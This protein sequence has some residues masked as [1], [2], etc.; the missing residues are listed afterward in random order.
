MPRTGGEGTPVAGNQPYTAPKLAPGEYPRYNYEGPRPTSFKE[1]PMSA[2]LVRQGEILPIEQRLPVAE[3]VK[4]MIPYD[5]IGVYGGTVR[6]TATSLQFVD[7]TG[8]QY[9]LGM[10]GQGLNLVPELFTSFTHSQD[11]RVFTFTIP[12]GARWSDGYPFTMEDVRF[13][14]EDMMLNKELMP[15]LPE[16]LR[17][18]I[19]G[20]DMKFTVVDDHTFTVAFDDPNWS[21]AE[22][23]A[24]NIFTGVKG[25]PRCFFAPSHV[26]KRYHIKYNAAEMPALLTK[27]N[28]PDWIKLVTTIRNVRGFTGIP[29]TAVPTTYDPAYIYKGEHYIPWMGGWITKEFSDNHIIQERNHYFFGVDP[30]GN[31]LP[32]TDFFNTYR[33]ESREVAVFRMMAGESDWLRQDMVLNEMPLYIS[34][35]EK[36]D[37]SIY[38]HDSPDGADSTLTVNQEFTADA[39]LGAL[40]RTAL[41]L[42]WDRN[43]T[44]ETVASGLGIPQNMIPHQSTP[45][46]PGEEFRTLDTQYD[47]ARAKQIMAD[48]G[49][50]DAN[51][52]GFLD[53]K[54]GRG[55][56]TLFSQQT[57]T[58]FPYIQMQQNDWAKLG[59]KLDIREDAPSTGQRALNPSEYFEMW[60]STEGGTNPW[61]SSNQRVAP[62]AAHQGAPAIGTYYATRGETG[63]SPTG[64][65]PKYTDALGKQAAAGTYPA[66]ITGSLKKLQDLMTEGWTVS[67]LSPE[68]IAL[69]KEMFKINA[70]EK[71]QIGGLAFS[72][73]FRA[74]QEKRNNFRN[75]PKNWSPA[76]AYPREQFYFEDGLDNIS[77]N[78]NRSEKYTSIS[79]LS[80]NYWD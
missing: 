35:M 48:L 29:S 77:H 44:N 14:M 28:Q 68:R 11:G 3:D 50:T 23:S 46:F 27:Y 45:Y 17:S 9:G 24:I 15:G 13:A 76:S 8:L 32:Y 55:P 40:L 41:S 10:D 18:P 62:I 63:M 78:G 69:G 26:Y 51:G 38:K 65:D 64:A 59:I 21:F 34:N 52:D 19:T 67:M 66:D 73:I 60:S 33:V 75:V 5:E 36:G 16:Q 58:Y 22:S 6:V 30:E 80:P 79:F 4:V 53:R 47:L 72:G 54:D 2:D 20:K 25:C 70:Q 43:S 74:L 71:Y 49:Y 42:A 61:S 31:Q 12:R 56:L 37:Y 39:E 57:V 1:S 7:S